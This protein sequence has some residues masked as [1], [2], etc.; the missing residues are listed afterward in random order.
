MHV[1]VAAFLGDYGPELTHQLI[2]SLTSRY[3]LI[4]S[5]SKV[6]TGRGLVNVNL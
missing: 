2:T 3:W 4:C 6:E 1:V 5:I